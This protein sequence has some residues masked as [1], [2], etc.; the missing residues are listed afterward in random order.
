MDSDRL[1][2]N[3][4]EGKSCDNCWHNAISNFSGKCLNVKTKKHRLQSENNTCEDWDRKVQWT[5]TK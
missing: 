2:K 1:A 4:L 5:M 3:L